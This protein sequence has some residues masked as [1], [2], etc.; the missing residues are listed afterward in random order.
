MSEFLCSA[1]GL[2]LFISAFLVEELSAGLHAVPGGQR[3]AAI[4]QGFTPAQSL[5]WILLPQYLPSLTG[6]GINLVKDTSLAFILNMPELTTLAGQVNN[7]VQV[8]PVALFAFTG[9]VYYLLCSGL[10]YLLQR[11]GVRA[12]PGRL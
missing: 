9:V 4:R 3:E 10:A 11:R 12:L 2:G 5:R 8:Y 1:W 6:I 7:R